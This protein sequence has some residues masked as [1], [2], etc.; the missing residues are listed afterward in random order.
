VCLIG[1]YRQWSP[2]ILLASQDGEFLT[3]LFVRLRKK[4]LFVHIRL[5]G[6]P[7]LMLFSISSYEIWDRAAHFHRVLTHRIACP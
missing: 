5:N 7:Y 6:C 2:K 4:E 1:D 3:C